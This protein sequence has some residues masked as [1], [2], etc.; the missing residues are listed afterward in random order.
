[1]RHWWISS[2]RKVKWMIYLN[3]CSH[4]LLTWIKFSLFKKYLFFMRGSEA[5]VKIKHL[6][7][8]LNV[9]QWLEAS[10]SSS[11]LLC[12]TASVNFI[13]KFIH[14][15]YLFTLGD[16]FSISIVK[17][18]VLSSLLVSFE[19]EEPL[20]YVE[21]TK[22]NFRFVKISNYHSAKIVEFSNA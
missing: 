15:Q 22:G 3:S 10:N 4:S 1:M 17:Y 8:K 2:G 18:L 19:K 20:Y 11:L 12:R 16:R 7:K 21:R 13:F 14:A 9:C 6:V 5:S